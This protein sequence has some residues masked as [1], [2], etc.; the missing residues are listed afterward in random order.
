M[1]RLLKEL[2]KQSHK[3]G[4]NLSL[5]LQNDISIH[6]SEKNNES[7]HFVVC[8]YQIEVGRISIYKNNKSQF[9]F[10]R[11]EYIQ[12]FAFLFGE[13]D[14][15]Q[16]VVYGTKEE[17]PSLQEI[18]EE[19]K[20]VTKVLLPGE[21]DAKTLLPHNYKN[22][23]DILTKHTDIFEQVKAHLSKE[24]NMVILSLL[25]NPLVKQA[26]IRKDDIRDYYLLVLDDSNEELNTT[27]EI[28]N[29]YWKI[30]DIL[31]EN[32]LDNYYFELEEISKEEVN[33]AL[34]SDP[35]VPSTVLLFEKQ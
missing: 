17:L 34:E 25:S 20:I 31:P 19:Y 21:N 14:I 5:S 23:H 7:F 32:N 16:L 9:T 13:F 33:D 35:H 26:L 24:Q 15:V 12:S 6:Y 10:S 3:L 22:E 2:G 11:K 8:K 27:E 4:M 18:T 30:S 28:T 29:V 1:L